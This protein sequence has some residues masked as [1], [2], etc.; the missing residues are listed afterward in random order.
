M[1]NKLTS[2]T[3]FGEG[4]PKPERKKI[5]VADKSSEKESYHFSSSGTTKRGVKRF[6]SGAKS[7]AL[8]KKMGKTYKTALGAVRSKTP[9][10]MN[11]NFSESDIRGQKKVSDANRA[12]RMK[13]TF[14]PD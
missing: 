7:S 6:G 13:N 5:P 4:D 11:M 2:L 10:A 1:S 12:Y 3:G 14:S 9:N 8:H